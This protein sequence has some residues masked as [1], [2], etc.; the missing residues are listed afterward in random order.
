MLDVYLNGETSKQQLRIERTQKSKER[1][2][3][4]REQ[5]LINK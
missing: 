5:N 1:R 4:R 2:E 3:R